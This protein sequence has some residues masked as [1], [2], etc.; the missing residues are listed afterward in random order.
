MDLTLK[1]SDLAIVVATFLGPIVAVQAQKFLDRRQ[2]HVERRLTIFRTL[3]ATR[4]ASLSTIHVEALN[5]I[6]IE[7]YGTQKG[8]K[9]VVTAWRNYFDHL[10]AT[11]AGSEAW[12][13]KRQELFITLLYKLA[14]TLGYN[15][16]ESE[17]KREVYSP[18]AHANLENQQEVIRNGM[19][20]IFNGEAAF[21]LDIKSISHDPSAV[22]AQKKLHEAI[23]CWLK[24]N[25][26]VKIQNA[27]G[28]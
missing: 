23:L 1:L 11:E 12:G 21:P 6:P 22:D 5:A 19:Y 17:L 26:H 15:F 20:K 27:S 8:F 24:E 28:S 18:R 16:S 2:A 4:A 3:M 25:S 9:E 13:L 14:K 7:F 10:S